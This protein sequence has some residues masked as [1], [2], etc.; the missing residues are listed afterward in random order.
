MNNYWFLDRDS[1]CSKDSID[2]SAQSRVDW[3]HTAYVCH[4]IASQQVSL[5]PTWVSIP[6]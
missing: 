4:A 5:W 1:C 6:P 2:N 3:R